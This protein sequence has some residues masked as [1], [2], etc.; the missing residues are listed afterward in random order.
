LGAVAGAGLSVAGVALQALLRNPLAEPYVLGVSGGASVGA[1][2]AI[3]LGLTSAT[4]LGA[5]VVPIF[6]LAGGLATTALVHG[7]GASVGDV[8]GTSILLVGVVVNMIASAAITFVKVLVE[9]SKVQEL[10]FWLTGF[11]D[12]PPT[13]SLVAMTVYVGLGTAALF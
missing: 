6:A 8:R 2:L 1:T 10:I 9:R 12:V 11:L 13:S 3:L 7:L 4:A 5:S